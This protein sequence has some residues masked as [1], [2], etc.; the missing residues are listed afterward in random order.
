MPT[1]VSRPRY[2][3]KSC[4]RCGNDH[5]RLSFKRFAQSIRDN[6]G[7]EWTHWARCPQTGDPVLLRVLEVTESRPNPDEDKPDELD[8]A[9]EKFPYIN[10]K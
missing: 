8:K 6:N 7:I 1:G 4:A 10:R 2:N 5:E 3:V 9:R